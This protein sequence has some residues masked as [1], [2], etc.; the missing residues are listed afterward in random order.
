MTCSTCVP[1]LLTECGWIFINHNQISR[2]LIWLSANSGKF[3]EPMF[4]QIK[5]FKRVEPEGLV[6]GK[7]DW[8]GS[9]LRVTLLLFGAEVVKLSVS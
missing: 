2:G 1:L 4:S 8:A 9:V 5:L 7:G 6:T 3:P